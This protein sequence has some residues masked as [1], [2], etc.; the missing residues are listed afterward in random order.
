MRLM[1]E[2]KIIFKCI[3]GS[4]LYGTDNPDSDQDFLGVFLP[5]TEDL[6]GVQSCPSEWTE[7]KKVSSGDRNGKGDV[8]CKY[9]SL[10]RFFELAAAGQPGTRELFYVPSD[11]VI[12]TTPEWE[13]IKRNSNLFLS[14]NGLSAFIGFA[15]AQMIK[16]DLKGANLTKIRNILSCQKICQER[17]ILNTKIEEFLSAPDDNGEV[18]FSFD[19]K[20]EKFK[21]LEDFHN[22]QTHF[23]IE[24]VGKKFNYG[25]SLKNVFQK[26]SSMEKTY[27]SRSEA[28]FQNSHDFKN[29]YHAYRLLSEIE[30]YLLTG[31]ITLPRPD[32]DFLKKIR[33]GEYNV[34]YR[35]ELETRMKYIDSE[36]APKSKL[37]EHPD[38]SK[39][40]KLCQKILK[41]HIF[42]T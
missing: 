5:S 33:T 8:D 26:L 39:V 21:H 19:L 29:L 41:D 12:I 20:Q 10:K 3:I 35:E 38:H 13:E 27:G 9:Y 28:A 23:L 31:V 14:K 32:A 6:L 15:K 25:V 37:P 1:A 42:G 4:K 34:D 17:K 24:V 11:K 30:E 22:N 16:T 40:N 7:N 36:I 18:H 2:R